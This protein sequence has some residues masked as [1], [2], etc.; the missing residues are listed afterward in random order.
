L[1]SG[2]G[3]E[4]AGTTVNIGHGTADRGSALVRVDVGQA[5]D[6][7][8]NKLPNYRDHA[9]FT[10]RAEDLGAIGRI[11]AEPERTEVLVLHGTPGVG[12]TRIAVEYALRNWDSYPGGVFF[13]QLDLARPTE[14]ADLL[15]V[16]GLKPDADERLEEQCR[17][18]LARLGARPTLLIYDNVPDEGVLA[19]WLP[20]G[21]LA[22]HVLATST[23]AYWSS[24]WTTHPID[25]LSDSD[26]SALVNK[27]VRDPSAARRWV[28]PLVR[29]ARGITVELCAAAKAM[30][31]E[32]SHGRGGALGETLAK[33]TTSSFGG[34]WGI[35]TDDARLVLQSAVLFETS[36]IPPEAL[37]ALWIGEGWS[38]ARFNAALDAAQDRTLI[39]AK[40]EAFDVHQCVARFVREQREPAIPETVR[41]CHFDGFVE[42]ARR[43]DKHPG[44][45]KRNALLRAYPTD[46]AFWDVV[47]PLWSLRN[48]TGPKEGAGTTADGY[49]IGLGL[50]K[51][52]QFD[53]ARVWSERAV[54][55]AEKGDEHGRIDDAMLGTSLH[56]VGDCYASTGKYD[57]ARGWFERAVAAKEKGDVH[58]R[59]D[60]ASLGKSLHHVG[61]CYSSTGKHDEARGWLER[62]VAAKEKGDVHGRVDHESLG[63]SRSALAGLPAR[64]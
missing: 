30:D 44:D 58:G 19:A 4:P 52:G 17:R 13:V 22:Y 34:A 46:V 40:G 21:G 6:P 45:P 33:V 23:C 16:F 31:Y 11:L 38:Q 54:A 55:E 1:T 5:S 63:R 18:V 8:R 62:A 20:T 61:V 43:F 42:A 41:E 10:G 25:L 64:S 47:L 50:C 29:K 7:R 60:P 12:K 35:L 39:V 24:S 3:K 32:T 59:V 2:S 26:A 49:T 15:D 56:Q 14:L 53:H 27:V 57:E 9:P 28:E 37:R 36:R 51:D 48:A